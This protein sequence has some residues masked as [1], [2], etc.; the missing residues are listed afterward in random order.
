VNVEIR[1]DDRVY[2]SHGANDV[3]GKTAFPANDN[4]RTII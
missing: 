4:S 3:H 2:D 1:R